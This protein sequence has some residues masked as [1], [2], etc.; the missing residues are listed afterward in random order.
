M[1]SKS[2]P[3]Q[4]NKRKLFQTV[5]ELLNNLEGRAIIYGGTVRECDDM[6]KALKKSN[7][8]T[9]G[10]YHGKLKVRNK[11]LYLQIGRMGSLK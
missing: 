9:I 10:M 11:L 5:I 7:S 8:N 6:T 1:N 4:K 3:N 2:D